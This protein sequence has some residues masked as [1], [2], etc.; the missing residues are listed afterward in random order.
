MVSRTEYLQA[1]LKSSISSFPLKRYYDFVMR[2]Y[3][4]YYNYEIVVFAI[5]NNSFPVEG[6]LRN[7]QKVVLGSRYDAYRYAIHYNGLAK[8]GGFEINDD[9]VSF[10]FMG[11]KLKFY[12]WKYGNLLAPFARGEYSWLNV[13]GRTVVDIGA[14]IG[15]TPVYFALRGAKRVVAFE[16]Y[17]FA[18]SFAKK[19]VEENGVADKVELVNAGCAYDT[20]VKV[21]P[22]ETMNSGSTLKD[23]EEGV[24]IPVYSLDTIVEKFGIE[25][26]S[27]LK[28]NC[29]GC[30]YP[31]FN[32]ASQDALSKF[33]KIV[34]EY[35]DGY[36]FLEDILK[37]NGFMIE[38]TWPRLTK[39]GMVVGIIHAWRD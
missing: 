3:R 38:H 10:E 36:K 33:D 6:I 32:E 2:Y 9:Y 14:S 27:A 23:Y 7:G 37:R 21:D 1:K 13:K 17:P 30:E 20:V 4:A 31:L 19:N 15:D 35:H 5:L 11:K 34:I 28:V 25:E 22:E 26:G 12:G 39:D 16:P 29:E 18:F 8:Y 24:E